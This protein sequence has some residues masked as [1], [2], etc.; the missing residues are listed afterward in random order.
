[1]ITIIYLKI[2]HYGLRGI[3][4]KWICSYLETKSQYVRFN[5]MKSGLH[6]VTCGIPQGP[7]L[8]PIL[9]LLYFNDIGN[10]S[11]LLYFILYADDTNVFCKHENIDVMCKIVSVG[12]DKLS[13]WFA[14]NKLA[15]NICETNFSFLNRKSVENN[16]SINGANL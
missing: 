5:G 16:V 10:V 7:I 3:V 1:M 13:T 6:N 9:F 2:I 4:S 12:L 15:L 14:L 11:N 8:G